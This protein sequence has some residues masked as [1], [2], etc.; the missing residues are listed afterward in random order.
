MEI[1]EA[2]TTYL[3]AQTGL[4]SLIDRRLHSDYLPERATYPA[5]VWIN[6]SDV[7]LH[8]LSGQLSLTSPMIQYTA[9]ATTKA[10]AKTVANQLTLALNDFQGTMSGVEVQYIK[11]VNEFSSVDTIA[12]GTTKINMTDLEYEVNFTKE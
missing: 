5:V 1:E 2:L 3:L 10:Q 12:D 9:Y 11:L 8:S 4:T 7:K 6:V